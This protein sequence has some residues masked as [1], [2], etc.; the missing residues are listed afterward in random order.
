MADRNAGTDFVNHV[1]CTTSPI[2][3]RN[4]GSPQNMHPLSPGT[5]LVHVVIAEGV[6]GRYMSQH[7]RSGHQITLF[8]CN[9]I[10]KPSHELRP[11]MQL[12]YF[13]NGVI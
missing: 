6:F 11:K 5:C 4:P 10:A 8:F 13:E 1:I 12:F 9:Y 2:S 3:V 7:W